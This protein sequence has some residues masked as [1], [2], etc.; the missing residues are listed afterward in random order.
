M[1]ANARMFTLTGAAGVV[2]RLSN[3]G[4]IITSILAPDRQGRIADIVLGHDTLDGYRNNPN[5]L[6]A[7]IGRYANRIA[8]A[9]FTLDGTT[10]KLTANDG[11]NCL[12]GGR[13]G[14]D[15][16]LWDAETFREQGGEGVRLSHRSPDGDQGFPWRARLCR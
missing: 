2:V 4:G 14:F 6:G 10:F 5:Y 9:R 12:H 8:N 3:Y 16:V 7:I 11:P 13:R 1:I 15:Q